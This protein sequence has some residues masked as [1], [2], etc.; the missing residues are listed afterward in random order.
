ML[1]IDSSAAVTV[2][3]VLVFLG[4]ITIISLNY[5]ISKKFEKIAFAKGYGAEI[6]AFA[7]CFWLGIIGYIYVCA[8]P[9]KKTNPIQT[10]NINDPSTK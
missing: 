6:H 2:P 1:Y 7:L 4:I 9:N 3:I 5:V 8:L 10:D